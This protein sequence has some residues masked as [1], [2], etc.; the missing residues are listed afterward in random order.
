MAIQDE[1]RDDLDIEVFGEIGKVITLISQSAPTYN[2]RGEEEDVV[3][4]ST[5]ITAV[6]YNITQDRQ[7]FEEIGNINEGEMFVAV[8]Y[9]QVIA[10]NDQMT[11]ESENWFVKDIEKNYLPDNVVTIVRIAKTQD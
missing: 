5:Q 9:D 1:I 4:T 6:P 11:I 2:S 8:R 3:A 7:T 10:V